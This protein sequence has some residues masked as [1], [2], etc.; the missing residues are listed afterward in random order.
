MNSRLDSEIFRR[1]SKATGTM[2]KLTKTAWESKY[3]TEK[4]KMDINYACVP[5][6]PPTWDRNTAWMLS[7]CDASV[8]SSVSSG[9]TTSPTVRYCHVLEP[10]ACTPYSVSAAWDGSGMFIAWMIDASSKKFYTDNWRQEKVNWLKLIQTTWKLLR[11]IVPAG[12][13]QWKK[14]IERAD[15][16]RHKKAERKRARRK[17]NSTLPSSDFTCA[18]CSRDCHSHIGLHSHTRRYVTT[19]FVSRDFA[20]QQ[21]KMRRKRVQLTLLE[22]CWQAKM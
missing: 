18:A 9:K 4:P 12:D 10:P 15:L 20:C 16:K 19:S 13:G 7:I 17:N 2:S 14:S 6:G 8:A 3:L 22:D 21:R 11:V 1:I 5:I